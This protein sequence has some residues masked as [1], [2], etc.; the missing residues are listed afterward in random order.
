MTNKFKVIIH[1]LLDAGTVKVS[2]DTIPYIRLSNLNGLIF[3]VLDIL[4]AGLFYFA[5]GDTHLAV[6]VLAAGISLPIFS[7]GANHLGFTTLGRMSGIIIGTL[8]ISYCAIHVEPEAFVGAF[9]LVGGIFPFTHFKLKEKK[10]LFFCLTVPAITYFILLSSSHSFGHEHVRE[11]NVTT[12]FWL[13]A[14]C[15]YMPYFAMIAYFYKTINDRDKGITAS[16]ER[17]RSIEESRKKFETILFALSHDLASQL[18]TVSIIAESGEENSFIAPD[19][20]VRLNT[21]VRQ[22]VRNFENLKSIAQ[23]AAK[24]ESELK[25][26][27]APL[28][29]MI[30]DAISYV[31]EQAIKK[32]IEIELSS[33]VIESA[34]KVLVD[35]DIFIFQVLSNFLSNALKFSEVG[36][37]VKIDTKYLPNEMIAISIQ[38]HG[39]GIEPERLSTIFDW[40]ARSSTAG[41]K[42]EKGVGL[43]L[44]IAYRFVQSMNGTV[45]AISNHHK[46]FPP[47]TRGTTITITLPFIIHGK[48]KDL[49]NS[50]TTVFH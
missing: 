18:Q 47:E 23:T 42:G 28:L 8:L 46:K 12:K 44:P 21:N 33:G 39:L 7:L 40:N 15:F 14:L 1:K 25:L 9:M 35:K 10:A 22:M 32:G 30:E 43:G 26:R 2:A 5:L 45:E 37:K 31:S 36:Q 13:Q 20:I 41:T 3:C 34:G 38:D 49:T 29:D 16:E 4:L 48:K 17:A 27:E 24:G 6:A 19:R 11:Y 50:K